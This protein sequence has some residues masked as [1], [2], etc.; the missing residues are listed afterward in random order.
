MREIANR[1][2]PPGGGREFSDIIWQIGEMRCCDEVL[3]HYD[4]GHC[5]RADVWVPALPKTQEY[6][7]HELER[8]RFMQHSFFILTK[9]PGANKVQITVPEGRCRHCGRGQ[10][11][12][13]LCG[14]VRMDLVDEVDESGNRA[15]AAVLQQLRTARQLEMVLTS[16]VFLA[17]MGQ[18]CRLP[19]DV[20]PAPLWQGQS[21]EGNVLQPRDGPL[22][23]IEASTICTRKDI[24]DELR[25]KVM[26]YIGGA[27]CLALMLVTQCLYLFIRWTGGAAEPTS[28]S[29]NIIG[30]IGSMTAYVSIDAN[31]TNS[32]WP[33][34]VLSYGIRT[35]L[36]S[37][38]ILNKGS[39][40]GSSWFA[41]IMQTLGLLV[42]WILVPIAWVVDVLVAVPRFLF[43]M[44]YTLVYG[45]LWRPCCWCVSGIVHLASN[46]RLIFE[47]S[48]WVMPAI[49][50]QVSLI[51]LAN[52]TLGGTFLCIVVAVLS[53]PQPLSLSLQS[54]WGELPSLS[55]GNGEK[56]KRETPALW[57]PSRKEN[58]G[59]K[60][61][62]RGP[63][64]KAS[65]NNGGGRHDRGADAN[66]SSSQFMCFVC[67]ER[68]SHYMLEPCGHHVVCGECV[69]QIVEVASRGR[70]M[71][72]TAGG[73]RGSEK[74]G[75][76]CPSCGLAVKQAM[77]VFN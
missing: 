38:D 27:T 34:S 35:V 50:D 74:S 77:R 49:V 36:G 69:V 2:R 7:N 30:E 70:P 18:V 40:T 61:N 4:C 6:T 59:P 72:E 44:V 17:A 62:G 33:M 41:L 39:F 67:L 25:S 19:N 11:L 65:H 66:G 52:A 9:N 15:G 71:C 16:H 24:E 63:K 42:S 23:G 51:A 22:P 14:P 57:T 5:M 12:A 43:S 73:H 26:K 53:S 29:R 58:G 45:L 54:V 75:G 28:F 31:M 68:P 8:R 20:I 55:T 10:R 56:K 64:D 32:S 47:R 21:A 3:I 1:G 76:T 48:W 60:H 46:P 37:V 13:L